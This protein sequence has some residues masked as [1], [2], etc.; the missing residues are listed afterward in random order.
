[1][2][3]TPAST[4]VAQ[5]AQLQQENTSALQ[6]EQQY[7][8]AVASGAPQTTLNADYANLS[9]LTTNS[10]SLSAQVK[11][12]QISLNQSISNLA[13]LADPPPLTDPFNGEALS[14]YSAPSGNTLANE[15]AQK[16]FSQGLTSKFSKLSS[17]SSL[18]TSNGSFSV[19]N[20]VTQQST[21]LGYVP[22]TGNTLPPN[23]LGSNSLDR[24]DSLKVVLSQQPLIT[25][26]VGDPGNSVV[27]T[28]MPVI[29]ETR[30]ANY[31]S[32]TPIQHPG[33]ILKYESSTSRSWSL[34]AKLVSRNITEASQN[35]KYINLIRSWVMPFYGTGTGTPGTVTAQYLGSPPPILT[36]KAYGSKMIGPVSCILLQYQWSW[37]NDVDWIETDAGD[38]FPVMLDISLTLK[39]SFSPSEYSAFNILAYRQGDM[40][41]AFGGAGV[42]QLSTLGANT[43]N[44]PL[45]VS[46]PLAPQN[47]SQIDLSQ[48]QT[49]TQV[50]INSIKSAASSTI[51]DN[52]NGQTSITM[53]QAQTVASTNIKKIING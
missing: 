31:K 12:S 36:L 49:I 4:V 7:S 25:N 3:N 11:Q 32:F 22:P 35:E 5:Q 14:N 13:P 47:P 2:A 34:N 41:A 51:T 21:V 37:P 53:T 8:S 24:T 16:V 9:Q 30:D 26:M 33:E 42:S 10:A 28:V 38:P 46:S 19:F 44:S 20:Q 18:S 40:V 52:A 43:P 23:T 39:E 17:T 6:A 27:F 1:M 50:Q 45:A 15:A 29:S 48:N